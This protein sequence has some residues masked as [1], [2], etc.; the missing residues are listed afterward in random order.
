MSGLWDAFLQR[1]VLANLC[2]LETQRS[3]KYLRSSG[4]LHACVDCGDWHT[5]NVHRVLGTPD[6]E[7]WPGVTSF[8][9]FKSSFPRWTRDT[10]KPLTTGLDVAGLD[11]LERMLI[12]DPAGRISA[13]QACVHPYFELGSGAYS[14]RNNRING[15]H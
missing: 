13:K 3:M 2:S 4:K 5:D 9:D 8:P 11:L 12:Y 15:Y 7:S 10:T 14:G 1:C 6:E